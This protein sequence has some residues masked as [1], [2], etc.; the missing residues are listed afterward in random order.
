MYSFRG[1]ISS[2]R[3]ILEEF[4]ISA[5]GNSH[6]EFMGGQIVS[7]GYPRINIRVSVDAFQ[8]GNLLTLR[9]IRSG[10][11]IKTFSAQSPLVVDFRDEFF[12]PG[13]KIYYRLDVN[14]KKNRT[15]VSNPIFVEFQA[16]SNAKSP[17]PKVG[18]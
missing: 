2:P 4:S 12:E 14:D 6:Q 3:L 8:E 15:L 10:N 18:D 7:E 13:K 16:S 17:T 5:P 9:L 11:L 1:D